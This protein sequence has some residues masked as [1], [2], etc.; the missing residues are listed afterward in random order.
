MAF[1]SS[2]IRSKRSATGP[3]SEQLAFFRG[4]RGGGP[5]S[6]VRRS[7]RLLSCHDSNQ[8]VG[9]SGGAS[10]ALHACTL[11]N[12][13][14]SG[15]PTSEPDQPVGSTDGTSSDDDF[16]TAP[17]GFVEA[18]RR[19]IGVDVGMAK[20]GRAPVGV[21]KEFLTIKTRCY[22]CTVKVGLLVGH[23]LPPRRYVCALAKWYEV[24]YSL[25]MMSQQHWVYHVGRSLCNAMLRCK[26]GDV[27][28]KRHFSVVVVST[29]V[30]SEHNG[31]VNQKIVHMLQDVDRIADLDWCGFL[32][33]S[34]VNC[35]EDW[36]QRKR[37]RTHH[38]LNC[39]RDVQRVV[40]SLKG[41][42]TKMLKARESLEI[43]Y[44][45]F[46]LG[47]LEEKKT[48]LHSAVQDIIEGYGVGCFLVESEQLE[49][50]GWDAFWGIAL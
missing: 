24:P 17:R 31:Y 15:R 40:S 32:L 18:D 6:G 8:L 20:D 23:Q 37:L 39:K 42:S 14:A 45:G 16:Q 7:K 34:L 4:G 46:G 30:A 43:T 3:P 29:L 48:I 9:Y 12:R 47:R 2:T 13:V 5:D 50:M 25:R 44:G 1:A 41:W 36:S 22:R 33:K 26:D 27:W 21:F 11:S 10:M 28:F 49:A 35:H 38:L 19:V